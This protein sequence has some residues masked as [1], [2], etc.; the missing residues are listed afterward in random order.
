MIR[1]SFLAVSVS[2][3]HPTLQGRRAGMERARRVF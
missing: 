1:R 2:S 3:Q